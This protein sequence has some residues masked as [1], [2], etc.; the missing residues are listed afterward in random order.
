L[1]N[2]FGKNIIPENETERLENLDK[3]KIIYSQSEPVFNELAALAATLHG[4]PL[5][6]I[7]FVAKDLVWTKAYQGGEGGGQTER[8]SSLCSLAIL[9]ESVT[10]FEDT[11]I[12]PILMS[13]PMVAGEFG[14]R[15]YAAAPIT[16]KDGFN[17]GAVCILDKKSRKFTEE[18]QEK[19]LGIARMVEIEIEKRVSGSTI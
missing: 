1:E 9:K 16:T 6:M 13:N 2:T 10:V 17:I 8:G 19:L 3:Y 12:E 15:F 7:N 18:D 5:A 11:L 14:L 4:V